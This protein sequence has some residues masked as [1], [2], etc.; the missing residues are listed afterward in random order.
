MERHVEEMNNRTIYMTLTVS[1]CLAFI[2]TLLLYTSLS[3]RNPVPRLHYGVFV[4][5]LPA[6]GALVVFRVTKLSISWRGVV[7]IYLLLFLLVLSQQLVRRFLP[8][9]QT[10]HWHVRGNNEA[11][12]QAVGS[13]E[14]ASF[15]ID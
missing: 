3:G 6:L 7:L 2:F 13:A 14:F 4:S 11:V 12:T 10:I 5:V 1:A 9:T 8:L 15:T